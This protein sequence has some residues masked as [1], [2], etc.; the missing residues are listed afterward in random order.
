MARSPLS[1]SRASSAPP[2]R[3][4]G[5]SSMGGAKHW[6]SVPRRAI[7]T[8]GATPSCRSLGTPIKKWWSVG[9]RE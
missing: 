5:S 9:P 8:A 3:G 1:C 2:T 6:S 4:H 7:R